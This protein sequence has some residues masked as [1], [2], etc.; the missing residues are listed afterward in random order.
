M[1][2]FLGEKEG[3]DIAIVWREYKDNWSEDEF[4]GDKEFIIKELS[5]REIGE[6]ISR[7]KPWASHIV[8]VNGQSVLT[9]KL[10][11]HTAEILYIEPEFKKLAEKAFKDRFETDL[12]DFIKREVGK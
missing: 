8:Y 12:E 5:P 1:A 3:K 2:S 7:G 11:K 4:K 9:P 6:D 10:G